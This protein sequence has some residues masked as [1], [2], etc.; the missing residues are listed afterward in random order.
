MKKPILSLLIL[1][2]VIPFF[3]TPVWADEIDDWENAARSTE[4]NTYYTAFQNLGTSKNPRAAEALIR[5]AQTLPEN[6]QRQTALENLYRYDGAKDPRAI[7]VLLDILR[8]N[9]DYS[10]RGAAAAGLAQFNEV[11]AVPDLLAAVKDESYFLRERVVDAL[12][13]LLSQGYKDE[14]VFT[15]L[16]EIL[17]NDTASSVRDS[18]A[19]ALGAYKDPRAVDPLINALQDTDYLVRAFAASALGDIGDAKAVEPLRVL[20]SDTNETA[21]QYAASALKKLGAGAEALA[22]SG[23]TRAALDLYLA[24]LGSNSWN[25]DLRKKIIDLTAKLDPKPAFPEEAQRAMARGKVEFQN[26]QTIAQWAKPAAE[27]QK[28]SDLAPWWPDTY[29]N[30]GLVLE[31]QL[32]FS[33]AL[34]NMRMYLY[35][36]PEAPDAAQVQ[37]KVY[38]LEYKQEN[39]TKTYDLVQQAAD[40]HNAGQIDAAIPLLKEAIGLMPEYYLAHSNLG[41]AYEQQ[42]RFKEGVPELEEA[43]RLGETDLA[44]FFSLSF[45]YEKGE[46]NTDKALAIL[47]EGVRLNPYNSTPGSYGPMIASVYRNMGYYYELKTNYKTAIEYYEKAISNGHTQASDIQQGIDRIRP[48]A[49]N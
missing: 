32:E 11:A 15:V 20:M 6:Y 40:L 45:C 5:L 33:R 19:L 31:K 16:L 25:M 35:A 21:R 29:F 34:D 23:D 43:I 30:L 3:I 13:T 44:V 36:A 4:F 41:R 9:V 26:A 47:E 1:L 37:E 14:A 24:E 48:Y 12:Q 39:L 22:Q 46:E 2:S 10:L 28:A 38:Q 49:G 18:A 27:F 8:S 42:D 17:R 7:P